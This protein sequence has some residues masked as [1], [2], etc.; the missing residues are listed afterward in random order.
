VKANV[1]DEGNGGRWV[2][3]LAGVALSGLFHVA[4]AVTVSQ[5]P[6][7][8][9]KEPVWIE[10]AV[11]VTE[12]PPPPPPEPEPPKPEPEPE[13]PKPKVEKPPID[14]KDI[15]PPPPEN[16]PPPPPTERKVRK[17]TQGLTANSFAPGSGTGFDAR[18]G[19][20]T[21]TKAGETMGLDEASEFA[22]VPYTSVATPPKLRPSPPL[23]VPPEVIEARIVGRVELELTIS[24]EGRV[25]DAEVIAKL[26]PAAD[27]ACVAH[28]KAN[29]R[30]SPYTQDG[31]AMAVKGVPFSCRF[32]ELAD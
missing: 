10:M 21:A 14:L 30:W 4:L 1:L 32:E 23:E 28:A 15:P 20:T 24:P 8:E 19:T 9:A 3:L 25:T 7:R 27:A 29:T 26:H 22:T 31:A 17:V 5:I 2:V 18:A 13:K 11:T 12:P 6:V 16:A